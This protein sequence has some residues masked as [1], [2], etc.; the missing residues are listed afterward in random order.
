MGD[1]LDRLA[2]A[3][4][5][6]VTLAS[7]YLHRTEVTWSQW[8]LVRDWAV[9][10]GYADL[11]SIGEGAERTR[12]VLM[13]SWYDVVKWLNAKSEMEGLV[14]VYYTDEA[15]TVVYRTGNL[16]ITNAMAKWT[17]TGYRLPTEAEWEYAARGKLSNKRFPWGDTISHQ[18]ANYF[19]RSTLSYDLSPTRGQHPNT[20]S[21]GT[22]TGS[23][24]SSY[25]LAVGSLPAND[26]GLQE[27][28]GNASEWCW[29]FYGSESYGSA[30]V[31]APLGPING[32]N[33]VHRGGN[34]SAGADVARTAFRSNTHPI[35]RFGQV[36]FR[37]ARSI[38]P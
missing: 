25:T 5:H 34:W 9:T 33:R 6:Q 23:W 32:P 29:D 15:Q 36:G 10:H 16:D 11:E 35:G 12:P 19:S 26:F 37:P 30:A 4:T 28:A 17:S 27:M 3:P 18:Q 8:A 14:P 7:F 13:V 31:T 21:A 20:Y 24:S 1:S 38:A 2:D 22:P